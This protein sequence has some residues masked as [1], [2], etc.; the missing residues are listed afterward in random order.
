VGY[1][2]AADAGV[3]KLSD[4]LALVTTV[5]FFTPIVDDPYMFYC[6]TKSIAFGSGKLTHFIFFVFL[7]AFEILWLNS[8]KISYLKKDLQK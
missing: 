8:Y 6:E 4:E 3:Y 5:D 7:G 2:T 1:N